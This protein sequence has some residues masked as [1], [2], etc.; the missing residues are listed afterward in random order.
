M[1][2]KNV[3]VMA[4][5]ASDTIKRF[6]PVIIAVAAL[7]GALVLLILP[8]TGIICLLLYAGQKLRRGNTAGEQISVAKTAW[9]IVAISCVIVMLKL[10]DLLGLPPVAE[11]GEGEE[12]GENK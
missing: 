8:G 6:G 11:A 12:K 7:I 4:T 9:I 10:A 3:G 2:F 5:H 1:K